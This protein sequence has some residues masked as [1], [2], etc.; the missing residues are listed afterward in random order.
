[1]I[2]TALGW[3][4]VHFLWQGTAIAA[5]LGLWLAVAQ[6]ARVRYASGCFALGLMA[7]CPVVTYWWLRQP[8]IASELSALTLVAGTGN[9]LSRAVVGAE[10]I[11]WIAWL[12]L[13]WL[14]GVA[15]L[16]ARL[17]L[18]AYAVHRLT[19][20]DARVVRD[21]WPHLRERLGIQRTVR[22]LATARLSGPVQAGFWKPVVVLPMSLLTQLPAEHLE[23][24]IAHEL[25]HIARHDY[26]VNLLQALVETLLFYHPAVWWASR[27]VRTER[28]LCCDEKAAAV[29]GN[30]RQYAEALLT[31]EE[32]AMT[33]MGLTNAATGGNLRARIA[34]LLGETER[35]AK[36]RLPALVIALLLVGAMILPVRESRAQAPVENTSQRE[37]ERL[38]QEV[39]ELRAELSARLLERSNAV[40]LS[41]R[42]AERLSQTDAQRSLENRRVA[43]AE[44]LQAQEARG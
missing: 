1:M 2:D 5:L 35:P 30:P 32:F 28:E 9:A 12:P 36:V 10:P 16:S 44:L 39:A 26:L 31:L 7:V 23:A 13:L 14:V 42:E 24:I 22:F 40:L 15:A 8:G 21:I 38:Q 3:T 33:G 25:A 34:R 29:T 18:A 27:V 17:M 11:R 37:I 4:L 41:A 43:E 20:R 6:S 19:H